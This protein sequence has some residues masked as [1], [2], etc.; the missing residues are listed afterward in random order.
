M[1]TTVP[2]VPSGSTGAVAPGDRPPG[3]AGPDGEVR[4]PSR[5]RAVV[6]AVVACGGAAVLAVLVAT[7]T[8]GAPVS[9]DG[10]PHAGAFVA[11]ATPVL[12]LATTVAGVL[13][14]G[15][16]LTRTVLAPGTSGGATAVTVLAG[17]WAAAAGALAGAGVH[18][19]AAIPPGG[20]LPGEVLATAWTLGPTRAWLVCGA[21]ALGVLALALAGRAG[22]GAL[23][24]ALAALVVPV[25]SGHAATM[26]DHA[27]TTGALVVHV[28]A[29][30]LW[31]GGLSGLVLLVRPGSPDLPTAARR[32]SPVALGCVVALG[33]SG[34][35]AAVTAL[36][37]PGPAWSSPY[38]GLLL[39]KA[40][41]LVVLVGCGAVHR[42]LTL[43]RLAE[44]GGG[45]F[46]RLVAVE[47]VVMA[48]AAGVATA[49]ARTPQA[50]AGDVLPVLPA[51]LG[52]RPDPLLLAAAVVAGLVGAA[53][54]RRGVRTPV[55]GTGVRSSAPGRA[56]VLVVAAV[57]VLVAALAAGLPSVA[58]VPRTVLLAVVLPA[59]LAVGLGRRGS[60]DGVV[61]ATPGGAGRPG[62]PARARWA[63]GAGT[64]WA[65]LVLAVVAAARPPALLEGL[66]PPG[67][68][69]V[70]GLGLV[71]GALLGGR[72]LA[73]G[74]P[75]R[76][77]VTDLT[78]AAT[79]T[80][81]LGAAALLPALPERAST[82]G[83]DG[84]APALD[85]A[86]PLDGAALL[87]G[88]LVAAVAAGWLRR[89]PRDDGR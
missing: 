23:G 36:G 27:G 58:A 25:Y 29:A 41:L 48:A 7:V 75:L 15:L 6:G 71:A 82:L 8:A 12:R 38:A 17:S 86:A 21:L 1:T 50:D 46:V 66:A 22:L 42:R 56:R 34:L 80:A 30:A 24:L 63:P 85:A 37:P 5:R 33:L 83:R 43:P 88:A 14:V 45:P 26:P 59:L 4:G 51:V 62:A 55:A 60:A 84:L 54:L 16:L 47:L 72:Q 57:V 32:F 87:G 44:G 73:L 64:L 3:R 65:V 81:V 89:R 13:V 74:R 78:T 53:A 39:A 79:L 18:E 69:L 31:V 76:D 68:L 67:H 35:L 10:L 70:P 20:L 11:W 2:A 61:E 52:W 77:R 28:L 49:L 40:G 9:T 19:I